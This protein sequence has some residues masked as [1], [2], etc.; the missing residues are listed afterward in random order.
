[1]KPINIQTNQEKVEINQHKIKKLET[2]WTET[3]KAKNNADHSAMSILNN[4]LN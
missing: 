1:M 3:E 2:N 4:G